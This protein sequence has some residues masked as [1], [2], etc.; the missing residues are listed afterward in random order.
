MDILL[1]NDDGI[2]ALGIRTLYH[3]LVKNHHTVHVVAPMRQQSGVS[4]CLTIFEPLRV[5]SYQDGDYKGF[6]VYGTPADCVKVALGA[7]L[8]KTPDLVISGINLGANVGPDLFYSGTVAAAIEG[9]QAGI[10]SLAV[11]YDDH[12]AQDISE[13]AAH[14]T[15]LIPRIPWHKLEKQRVININYPARPLAQVLGTTVCQQ[16]PAVWENVYQACRD[17]RNNPYF[18]LIGDIKEENIGADSDKAL[19]A[20]GYITI[21]PLRFDFTDR[22]SLSLLKDHLA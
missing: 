11:S 12:N 20:Q 10:P 13:Q 1:T 15:Q 9:S 4:Q 19:L 17:P 18:W 21:S 22:E 8:E 14:V 16:S 5:T 2:R 7:L 6:G 3:E